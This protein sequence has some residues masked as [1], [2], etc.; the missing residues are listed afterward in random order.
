ML[1]LSFTKFVNLFII[2]GP[3][4]SKRSILMNGPM[5]GTRRE[6]MEEF[7]QLLAAEVNCCFCNSRL[8]L[9]SC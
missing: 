1:S 6:Y 9:C 3:I 2:H 8:S 4:V 5:R 7:H